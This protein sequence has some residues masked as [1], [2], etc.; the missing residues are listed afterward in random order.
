MK[1]TAQ[2]LNKAIKNVID[3]KEREQLLEEVESTFEN[4]WDAVEWEL[5]HPSNELKELSAKICA[6]YNNSDKSKI[7]IHKAKL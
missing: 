7:R 6:A 3:E 4:E 5:E 2:N 1:K